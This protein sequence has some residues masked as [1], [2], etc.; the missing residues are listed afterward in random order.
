[1][2]CDQLVTI[3]NCCNPSQCAELAS[4]RHAESGFAL[5]TEHYGNAVKYS[6]GNEW[7]V[8][9]KPV[10]FPAGWTAIE[11]QAD[12][13]APSLPAPAEEVRPSGLVI[14]SGSITPSGLVIELF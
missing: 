2:Q 10:P 5:C 4:W 3:D 12:A 1:M 9:A 13:A 8:A 11:A 14:E 7:N 6:F